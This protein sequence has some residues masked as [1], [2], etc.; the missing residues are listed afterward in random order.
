VGDGDPGNS[1][2][3]LTIRMLEGRA[4]ENLARV[5]E[6]ALGVLMEHFAEAWRGGRCALTVELA[7]MRKDSYFKAIQT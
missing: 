6:A 1:F 7:G 4:P 5:G 3:H 2:A